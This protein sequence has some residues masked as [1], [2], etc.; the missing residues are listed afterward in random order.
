MRCN[1]LVTQ[2]TK[3][4]YPETVNTDVEIWREATA[5]RTALI[6]SGPREVARYAVREGGLAKNKPEQ[7]P[8]QRETTVHCEKQTEPAK[9]NGKLHII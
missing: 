7:P 8:T 3:T 6:T 5:I 4:S 9:D 2:D 1:V